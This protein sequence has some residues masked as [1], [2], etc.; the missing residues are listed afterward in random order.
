MYSSP[1]W[2]AHP[3]D[4]LLT[5]QSFKLPLFESALLLIIYWSF[6][7]TF[8]IAIY[9][10]LSLAPQFHPLLYEP[11]PLLVHILFV[12]ILVIVLLA[13]IMYTH[14]RMQ[15]IVDTR[16]AGV[17]V[18]HSTNESSS[19]PPSNPPTPKS[20]SSTTPSQKIPQWKSGHS[21]RLNDICTF[22]QQQYR[23]ISPFSSYSLPPIVTSSFAYKYFIYTIMNKESGPLSQSYVL[24]CLLQFLSIVGCSVVVVGLLHPRQVFSLH[25]LVFFISLTFSLAT[26]WILPSW[27]CIVPLPILLPKIIPFAPHSSASRYH[28]S[29]V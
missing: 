10:P 17:W 7:L 6:Y 23:L 26:N 8:F 15:F 5:S 29:V 3:Y 11:L 16:R 21:Y 2:I 20:S 22:E 13:A 25:L 4:L 28:I 27:V 19:A 12:Y 1:L 18:A 9:A 24:T 14:H